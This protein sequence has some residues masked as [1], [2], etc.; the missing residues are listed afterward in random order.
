MSQERTD[1]PG[2]PFDVFE[3]LTAI[4]LGLAAIGA[5]VASLQG[6]QWGGKQLEAFAE[7]NTLTTKAA[8]QYNEDT[9]L[10]NAD[11]AAVALA[12]QH[13]LEARDA[14]DPQTKDRHFTLA[15]YFLMNQLTLNAYKALELPMAFYVEDEEEK[16][17]GTK[18]AAPA[19]SPAPA[20]AS[21]APAAATPP[22]ADADEEEDAEDAPAA[23]TLAKDIPDDVLLASLT[24]ELD[25]A[26]ADEMLE[27][28]EAMF[29]QADA[30]FQDG[31]QANENGDQFDLASVFFTVALF[32][33]GLG[34][35]FKTSMR[36][37]FLGLGAIIFLGSVVF[38]A[39]LPWA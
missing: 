19:A 21:P 11:Y 38:M 2:R 27:E 17:S 6:G 24:S 22:A 12:K 14:R 20:A 25:E 15:S 31:R 13:I 1:E 30:K 18:P 4:L 23:G 9:V 34:L 5:S 35:V 32:F 10:M 37:G 7:A 16:A 3:L 28:G 39:R 36:W 29:K 26:Y 33:A 8:K